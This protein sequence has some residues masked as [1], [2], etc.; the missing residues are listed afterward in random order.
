VISLLSRFKHG[1]RWHADGVLLLDDSVSWYWSLLMPWFLYVAVCLMLYVVGE[2]P[3]A[4]LLAL[5]AVFTF[6]AIVVTN[7]HRV[8]HDNRSVCLSHQ[9]F[10][11]DYTLQVRAGPPKASKNFGVLRHDFLQAADTLPGA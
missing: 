2:G 1:G 5:S 6:I 7:G 4:G 9:S 3:A 11:K 8:G 10:A